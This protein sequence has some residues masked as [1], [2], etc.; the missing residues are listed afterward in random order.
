MLFKLRRVLFGRLR[1]HFAL[2]DF[3][4]IFCCAA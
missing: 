2:V 3:G 4:G 1:S